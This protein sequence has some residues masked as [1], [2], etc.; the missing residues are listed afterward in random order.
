MPLPQHEEMREKVMYLIDSHNGEWYSDII[1]RCFVSDEA[2]IILGMP[3]TKFGCPDKLV[4]H[5]TKNGMHSVKSGYWIAQELNRNGELGR[6]GVRES[7]AR[8]NKDKVW[9][10]IWRLE[11]PHELRTFLTVEEFDLILHV[12]IVRMR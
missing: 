2:R 4:W 9:S 11:V 7:S 10:S 1:G 5:L 8:Q 3:L 12:Q 6:K